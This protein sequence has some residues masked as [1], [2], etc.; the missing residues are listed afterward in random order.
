MCHLLL[1]HISLGIKTKR[2]KVQAI[3]VL[4]SLKKMGNI[5]SQLDLQKREV[6]P[7]PMFWHKIEVQVI[8]SS[9]ILK[10]FKN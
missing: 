2:D 5:L 7:R 8:M 10:Q 3:Y 4:S 6:G 9:G 1:F